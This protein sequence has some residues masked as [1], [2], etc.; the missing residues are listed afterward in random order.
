[1]AIMWN[2]FVT[3]LALIKNEKLKLESKFIACYSPEKR[4]NWLCL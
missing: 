4:Q 1:M 3:R 2:L